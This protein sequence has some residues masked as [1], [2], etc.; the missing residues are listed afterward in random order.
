MTSDL[1]N[2]AR[3]FAEKAHNDT[4]HKYGNESYFDGHIKKVVAYGY[5]YID[6]VPERYRDAAIAALYCHDVIEDCR[7]VYNDLKDA[8]DELTADIC[9]ALTNEKGKTRKERANHKYYE[10][11]KWQPLAPWCKLCDRLANVNASV[12]G[13]KMIDVYRKEMLEFEEELYNETY[14]AMWDELDEL[15]K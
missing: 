9:Y 15:L 13:H 14:K 1:I 4:N 2:R 7:V 3:F 8:T 5:K 6:L 10:G 11:I 12:N